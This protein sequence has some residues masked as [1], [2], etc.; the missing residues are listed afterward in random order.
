[1]RP[2][3]WRSPVLAFVGAHG[4]RLGEDVGLQGVFEEGLR[5]A[6]FE[7]EQGVE[8]VELEEVTVRLARGRAGASV[9]DAVK[10]VEAL[11]GA[12][13]ELSAVLG[14]SEG[15]TVALGGMFQ[16]SQWVQTPA[17]ASGSSTMRTK[18]WVLAGALDQARSGEMSSLSQV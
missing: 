8:G 15:R 5:G 12:I 3:E 10:V 1:M 9:A 16:M 14:V 13:V 6:R 7:T 2:H 17:G 11:A 4:L 18:D